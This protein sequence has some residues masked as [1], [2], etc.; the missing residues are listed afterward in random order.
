MSGHNKWSQIQHQKSATDKKRS[1]LFS[2]MLN[3][4][5]IAARSEPNPDFNPHLRS[6]V[7][8]ARE[9]NVP[10]GNIERAINKK[11]EVDQLEELV[12]EAYGPGSVA[13]IINCITDNHNRTISEIKHLLSENEAKLA[14]QGSVRWAFEGD[15][16][17][18]PQTISAEDKIK[19]EKLIKELEERDDTQKITTN[20]KL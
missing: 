14:E 3:A 4:I 15:Q 6:L 7:E 20:L 12:I 16:P 1:V 10:Q 5:S 13:I 11:S 18:F 9:N 17:K 2:K 8:K 19:I